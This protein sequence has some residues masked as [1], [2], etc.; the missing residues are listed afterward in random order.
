MTNQ[1]LIRYCDRIKFWAEMA[2]DLHKAHIEALRTIIHTDVDMYRD[3][4]QIKANKIGATYQFC[5]NRLKMAKNELNT[6]LNMEEI[7]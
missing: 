4:V 7:K 6:E 2:D 5:L 3:I 1:Q